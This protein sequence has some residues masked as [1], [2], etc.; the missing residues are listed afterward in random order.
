M[1][2]LI[3]DLLDLDVCERCDF[4]P[5]F[6]DS[7]IESCINKAIERNEKETTKYMNY[8]RGCYRCP[9]CD[10]VV[11]WDDTICKCGQH[12]KH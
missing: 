11:E 2:I 1:K 5:S 10:E 8:Y 9:S 3:N 7:D 4:S 12:I 6:C